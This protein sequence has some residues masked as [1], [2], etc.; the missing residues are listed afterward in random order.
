MK[1][2]TKIPYRKSQKMFSRGASR[3]QSINLTTVNPVMM[4]GGTRL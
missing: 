4:R 3:T 1:Y 2:R